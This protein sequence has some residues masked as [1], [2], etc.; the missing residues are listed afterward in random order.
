MTPSS[1]EKLNTCHPSLQALFKA[2]DLRASIQVVC[3]FRNEADQN[4]AYADGFSQVKWP[5]GKH[6]KTPSVAVDVVPLIDGRIEWKNE[7]AFKALSET[8]KCCAEESGIKVRWGG[9]WK[10]FV[11]RPHW[12][13]TEA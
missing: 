1:R 13:L 2:V 4:K 3:G 9:D 5:N 8:V 10:G 11:D 7:D 12:E 6:N